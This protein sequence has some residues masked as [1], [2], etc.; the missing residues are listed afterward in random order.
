MAASSQFHKRG[1]HPTAICGIFGATAA[2]ARLGGLDAETAASALGLA[3]SMASGIFAYLEEGT[4]TK[5]L[6]PAWAAHGGADRRAARC[7]RRRRARR[8]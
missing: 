6:H 8:R 4:A 2:A 5:P 1:F 7:P 3:G